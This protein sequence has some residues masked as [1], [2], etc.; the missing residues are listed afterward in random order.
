MTDRFL[1]SPFNSNPVQST[2]SREKGTGAH[3][4]N[5]GSNKHR[6]ARI[7]SS[8]G[9]HD[10]IGKIASPSSTA[11]F[12]KS[13]LAKAYIFE[14]ARIPPPSKAYNR[15]SSTTGQGTL[16]SSR[17]HHAMKHKTHSQTVAR[18]SKNASTQLTVQ[19]SS[20]SPNN[21]YTQ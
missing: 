6:G 18:N 8:T 17:S 3:I 12:N 16:N 14:V 11:A 5:N 13:N 15:F 19:K 10:S 4:Y 2:K 1:N 9:G 21:R 20:P 7:G